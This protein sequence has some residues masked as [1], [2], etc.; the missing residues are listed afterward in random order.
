MA[1]GDL[2]GTKSNGTSFDEVP[3][4]QATA[5]EIVTGTENAKVATPKN[6]KDAEIVPIHVGASAPADTTKLWLDTGTPVS[7]GLICKKTVNIAVS[8]T[9][10]TLSGS[11]FTPPITA[12]PSSFTAM[13]IVG[14]TSG[15]VHDI[16]EGFVQN[17][18]YY[19]ILIMPMDDS[20][21]T[22]KITVHC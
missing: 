22:V 20:I 3:A 16:L 15:L 6:I 7:G 21:S 4:L 13:Q 11:T 17:G 5:A 12:E 14:G 9:S 10:V 1:A 2:I 8:G 19:D 18:S